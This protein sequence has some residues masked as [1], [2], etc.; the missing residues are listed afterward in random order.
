MNYFVP[1]FWKDHDIKQSEDNAESAEKQL[2]HTFTPTFDEEKDEW[3]RYYTV[4]SNS[5]VCHPMV[6]T[7]PLS[8][9]KHVALHLGWTGAVIQVLKNSKETTG[10][11]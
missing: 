6:Y 2:G 5:G 8:K 11:C 3:S 10:V 7:H 4:N 1:N 9:R